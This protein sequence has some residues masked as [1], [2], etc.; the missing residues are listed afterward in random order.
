MSQKNQGLS[1]K[2]EKKLQKFMT[3]FQ[4]LYDKFH[5]NNKKQPTE[6]RFLS[7]FVI[8]SDDYR[9]ENRNVAGLK[10][11]RAPFNIKFYFLSFLQSSET[12]SLN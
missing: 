10:S 1:S 11:F 4:I 3:Y 5:L 7:Y 8:F 12:I 9:S 6:D 2:S